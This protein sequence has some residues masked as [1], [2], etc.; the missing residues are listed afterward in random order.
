[1]ARPLGLRH[2]ELHVGEEAALAALADVPFGLLVRL[3]AGDPDDVEAEL[4]CQIVRPLPSSCEGLCPREGD[5]DPRGRWPR[6]AALRGRARSGAA[7]RRGADRAARGLA[8]PSRRLDPQ[9]SAVGAEAADPRRRRRGRDRRHRR[10]RRHQPGDRQQRQ[11]AHR[12][13]DDGRHA[14]RADR[15][16]ARL[17]PSDSRRPLVRGGRGVSRSSSRRPTGCSCRAPGCRTANG[18]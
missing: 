16:P 10:A 2:R 15:R 7:R 3:G 18:C 1:M 8:Q 13:R 14:R 5:S 11:D 12:R 17:R 6:G 4:R 9:G